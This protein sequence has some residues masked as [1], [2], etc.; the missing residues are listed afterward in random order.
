[1]TKVTFLGGEEVGNIGFLS[2]PVGQPGNKKELV[3]PLNKAVEVT[4]KHILSK[5]RPMVEKGIFSIE[6]DDEPKDSDHILGGPAKHGGEGEEESAGTL[7]HG[8]TRARKIP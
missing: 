1:M 4:D 2:W 6:E 8:S 7:K 3:F 5:I